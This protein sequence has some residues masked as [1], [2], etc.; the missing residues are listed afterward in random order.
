MAFVACA[1]GIA[2][3]IALGNWQLRRAATKEALQGRMESSRSAPPVAPD[4]ASLRDPA[5]LVD[6][7]LHLSGRWVPDHVVYL[8]NRPR[9][10]RTGFYVLMGLALDGA[11]MR[12]VVVNRGWLPRDPADRQRIASYETRAGVVDVDGI[13]L[14]DEPRFLQLGD[15]GARPLK[16]I[17]QNFDF[18]AYARSSGTDPLRIVLRQDAEP[19]LR[20]GLDRGWPDRD[21]TLQSQIDR[22][23]GYAFQWFALSAA[24]AA[25]VVYRL[26]RLLPH[27]R[28]VRP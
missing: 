16:A 11:G 23:H 24:L 13:A 20:D 19:A 28:N 14:A 8:D 5:T 4:A 26:A 10:G 6:R 3:T 1:L 9:D 21:G 22:H 2:A 17:W 7:H 15:P 12:E 27:V 18:D 25:F